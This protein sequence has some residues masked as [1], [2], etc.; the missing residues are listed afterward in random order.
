[1]KKFEY[2][3]KNTPEITLFC[4]YSPAE[5]QTLWDPG[6]PEE[7]EIYDIKIN[8]TE[9]SED[10]IEILIEDQGY[11]WFEEMVME[12]KEEGRDEPY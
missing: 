11:N 1:M 3:P 6:V 4:T 9:I 5:P 2:N 10:L 7:I 8:D 12:R